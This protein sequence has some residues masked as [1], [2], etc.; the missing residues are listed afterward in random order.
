MM[1]TNNTTPSNPREDE[2]EKLEAHFNKQ[3]GALQ[4]CIPKE[5]VDDIYCTVQKIKELYAASR[6]ATMQAEWYK[7][8]RSNKLLCETCWTR[9][10]GSWGGCAMTSWNCARCNGHQIS[11]STAHGSICLGCAIGSGKCQWCNQNNHM[12]ADK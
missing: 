2:L 10:G 4:Y 12:L 5:G 9:R 6:E 8:L 1:S 3:M 11:G 7:S